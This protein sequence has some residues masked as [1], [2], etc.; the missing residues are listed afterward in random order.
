MS[1]FQVEFPA[2]VVPFGVES[3]HKLDEF[4]HEEDVGFKVAKK[5]I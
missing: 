4:D 2:A 3:G 5:V 1:L